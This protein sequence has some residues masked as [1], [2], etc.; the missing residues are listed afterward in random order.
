[1]EALV[2]KSILGAICETKLKGLCL[3]IRNG[4]SLNNH[5]SV[6]LRGEV[7]ETAYVKLNLKLNCHVVVPW[8]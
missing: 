4:P 2:Q 7:F 3:C 5:N 1:M 6:Y 8:G